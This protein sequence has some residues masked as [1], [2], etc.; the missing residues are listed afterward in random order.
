MLMN[1]FS[2]GLLN[3]DYKPLLNNIDYCHGKYLIL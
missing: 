2:V 3:N 1:I